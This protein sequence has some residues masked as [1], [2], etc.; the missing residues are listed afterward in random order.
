MAI[1]PELADETKGWL[2]KAANDLRAAEALRSTLPPVLDEAVFNWQQAAEKSL[3][4]FLT[5]NGRVFRKTHNLEATGEQCV[6]V[7][8]TL[9]ENVDSAVPLTEYDWKFRYPGSLY[10]PTSEEAADAIAIARAVVEAVLGRLP[11]ELRP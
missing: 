7:D 11:S 1:D 6:S 2:I 5:W 10:E 4:G 3:K 9:R 8:P